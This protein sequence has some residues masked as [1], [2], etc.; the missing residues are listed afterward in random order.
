MAIVGLVI[1]LFLRGLYNILLLQ[2]AYDLFRVF[3]K[4]HYI[5]YEIF[6]LLIF[7]IVP[8]IF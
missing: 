5:I 4:D 1:P 3:K 6:N 8:S 7:V 2:F